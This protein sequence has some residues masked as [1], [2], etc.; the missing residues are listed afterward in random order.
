MFWPAN[1]IIFQCRMPG[2]VDLRI[3]MG[4]PA[5]ARSAST[6]A[7]P[8]YVGFANGSTSTRTGTPAFH[9]AIIAVSYRVSCMN[10]NATSSPTVSLLMRFKSGVRQ[11]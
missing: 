2:A 3:R 4:M 8:T 9:R 7:L 6:C 1:S 11:F 10:Q 5:A